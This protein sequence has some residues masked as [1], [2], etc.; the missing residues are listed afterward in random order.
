MWL[1][2]VKLL[3]DCD[4][5]TCEVE[6]ESLLDI[7]LSLYIAFVVPQIPQVS[8]RFRRFC[9]QYCIGLTAKDY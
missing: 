8:T 5:M 1:C 3:Y 6:R 9:Y 7:L 2:F 4:E